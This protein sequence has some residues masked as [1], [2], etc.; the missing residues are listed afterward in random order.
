MVRLGYQSASWTS[1][2]SAHEQLPERTVCPPIR[3]P[4]PSSLDTVTR[5]SCPSEG[6]RRRVV[7]GGRRAELLEPR[8]ER[9]EQILGRR[10]GVAVEHLA[11]PAAA[12]A[13]VRSLGVDHPI[14]VE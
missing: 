1:V 6:K 4:R 7:G 3:N 11:E 12:E 5:S 10:A 2:R 13:A 8:L 14:G 9:L